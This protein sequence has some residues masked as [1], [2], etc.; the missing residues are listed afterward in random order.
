MRLAAKKQD[1]EN[2]PRGAEITGQKI[3]GEKGASATSG[4][5]DEKHNRIRA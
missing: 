1:T 4:C 5:V 2:G 3:K